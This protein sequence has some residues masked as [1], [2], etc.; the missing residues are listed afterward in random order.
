MYNYPL[1]KRELVVG[2]NKYDGNWNW[3]L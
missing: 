1:D 2:V 3:A